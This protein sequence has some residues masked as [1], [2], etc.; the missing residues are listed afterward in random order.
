MTALMAGATPMLNPQLGLPE[1]L[2][3][4]P[5]LESPE[6]VHAIFADTLAGTSDPYCMLLTAAV[7]PGLASA[8]TNLWAPRDPEAMLAWMDVWRD[9]LPTAVQITILD[10]LLFPKVP[11]LFLL[12]TFLIFM[13]FPAIPVTPR[14]PGDASHRLAWPG[15]AS[16]IWAL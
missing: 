9:T 6:Q 16:W 14:K 1:A 8:I 7:V 12:C 10:T 5:L 3:W 13:F 15:C 4:R 2:A 11:P